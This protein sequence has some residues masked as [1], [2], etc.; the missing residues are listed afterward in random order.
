MSAERIYL[1]HAAGGVLFPSVQKEMLRYLVGI[2]ASPGGGHRE[3]REAREELEKA[4]Q[5]VAT[6]LGAKDV[7]GVI[8]TSGGTEAVQSAIRG[9][10]EAVQNGT[11]YV[12][13]MEHP[14]VES[15]VRTLGKRGFTLVRVPV[16]AE[17]RLKWGEVKVENDKGLVCVH[18][19]HHDLGTV[20]KIAEARKFAD[21]VGAKLFVDATHGAG[22]VSFSVEESGA[23]LVALSGHRLGGPKGSGALW[24]RSGTAWAAWL[25]GGR[26][27]GDRR[28]GTENL[29]AI[30]GLGVAVEEWGKKG[31]A[32]RKE[33]GGA[34]KL[35]WHGVQKKVGI[36]KLH[37]APLG[38][39][40]NPA[41]LAVSFAGL[42]AE[43]LALVLDRV[44]LAVRGG[45]GCV[46]REMRVPP[47]M[48]A[49]GA[50][51]EEA[52]ALI[53]FTLGWNC[54]EG[55]T[56]EAADRVA[57]GVKRLTEALSA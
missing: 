14:A 26:Q 42:E 27:E 4:R 17:G 10:G 47:G 18:L 49:I 9:W 53:L 33:A 6:F 30:V 43:A 7:E 24:I 19:A 36:A 13:E 44:G 32:F 55:W 31:E 52:R 35:F 28:A 20:Q 16:D 3:G 34:Q 50:T 54:G 46:T 38:A 23:D 37:G 21:R 15:A 25:E 8:F 11:I 39:E 5:R 48:K 45:S 12:S 51:A 40:R 2:Q 29:P 1:D 57:Q 41:H 56:G 22:W